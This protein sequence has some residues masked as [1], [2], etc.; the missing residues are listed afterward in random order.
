M[1][2]TRE[3]FAG[4]R[5]FTSCRQNVAACNPNRVGF[6]N[7]QFARR[8]GVYETDDYNISPSEYL[9][10]WMKRAGYTTAVIG[11]YPA[12]MA[13]E[14]LEGWDFRRTLGRAQDTYNYTVY[15]G[16]TTTAPGQYQAD[17]LFGQAREFIAAT[18]S[19]WF[20]WLTPTNP[21][22]GDNLRLEPRPE[23]LDDWLDVV[24]PIV[25]DDMT[26]KPSWMQAL[27]PIDETTAKLIRAH[28]V[29]QLQELRA[30]DDGVAMLFAHLD[31]LGLLSNT[32]VFFTSDNGVMYGEH[33]IYKD[34]ASTKNAPYD[35]A[36]R[37]PLLVRG[38]QFEGGTST[39]PTCGHDITA[40]CL[41]VAGVTPP[42]PI[43]GIDLRSVPQDRALLHERH[44]G[45]VP[46]MP[47]GIGV[48]TSTR[49]LWRHDADDPDRYE[50]YLLDSDPD[51][52]VNVAYDPAYLAERQALDAALD[53]A[54]A[55]TQ[56]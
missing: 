15:D 7:G 9:A 10:T 30:V 11:K 27:S 35:G 51:E 32:I 24:W 4:G 17:Y 1:P 43:D 26:G 5:E 18:D 36:M 13:L 37:V 45:P 42:V 3:A 23:D 14:P 25:E 22:V 49:K 2:Q 34:I 8:T 31:S 33:R 46:G 44:G 41:A 48:T 6:L 39:A 28:A 55:A 54:L 40:T 21:H 53:A 16:T 52:L 47:N 20:C 56:S 38:P 50:M 12:Q 29:Q 19:P